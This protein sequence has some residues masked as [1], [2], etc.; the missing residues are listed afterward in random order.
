MV[1]KSN[2][3]GKNNSKEKVCKN[4][5]LII[6]AIWTPDYINNIGGCEKER[7]VYAYGS[8][9]F[10]LPDMKFNANLWFSSLPSGNN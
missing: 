6:N 4:Y 7:Q 3:Y 1:T 10:L 9:S 5:N 8:G 2:W